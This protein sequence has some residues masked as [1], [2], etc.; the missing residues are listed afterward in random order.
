V[1]IG[2]KAAISP[3]KEGSA[4]EITQDGQVVTVLKIRAAPN[5]APPNLDQRQ[6]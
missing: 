3:A 6:K 1:L 2:V 4:A 5:W